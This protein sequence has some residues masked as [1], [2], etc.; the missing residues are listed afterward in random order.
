MPL[1]GFPWPQPDNQERPIS[2]TSLI[3]PIRIS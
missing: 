1:H 3:Q 2:V